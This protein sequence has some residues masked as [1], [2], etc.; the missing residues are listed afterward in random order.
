MQSE[1][2]WQSELKA[3]LNRRFVFDEK[4]SLESL[5]TPDL[6]TRALSLCGGGGEKNRL[7]YEAHVQKWNV[8][9]VVLSLTSIMLKESTLLRL[10]PSSKDVDPFDAEQPFTSD[11]IETV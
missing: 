10:Q 8:L 2:F 11:D 9:Q 7:A 5:A 4:A 1:T 3:M 6:R